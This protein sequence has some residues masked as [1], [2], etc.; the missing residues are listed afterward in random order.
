MCA[1]HGLWNKVSAVDRNHGVYRTDESCTE[2]WTVLA[3]LLA[4]DY[5]IETKKVCIDSSV[6]LLLL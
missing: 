4:F 2:W 6:Y 1:T 3:C 5:N